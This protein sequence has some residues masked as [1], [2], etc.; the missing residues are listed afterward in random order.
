MDHVSSRLKS[1]RGLKILKTFDSDVFS[2]FSVETEEDNVDT[3]KTIS[4]VSRAWASR[5]IALDPT[6]PIMM[7]MDV[8]A[9][10][11]SQHKWTGVQELHD[12]GILGKGAKVA[13]VD[14]G[15]DYNHPAVSE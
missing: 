14:T 2:G 8:S 13:I 12:Q 15:I 6:E 5:W 4:D 3:L 10:N 1:R 11:Y 9:S 7:T